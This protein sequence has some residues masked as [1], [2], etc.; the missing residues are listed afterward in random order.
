MS[1]ASVC[2]CAVA[3][4][5]WPAHAFEQKTAVPDTLNA[6][7][8]HQLDSIENVFVVQQCCNGELAACLKKYPTC[9][10][11][12]RLHSF[13]KWLV[14]RKIPSA[15]ITQEA[16]R[17]YESLTSM[18]K[19]VIDTT[20]FPIA[21]DKR[22]PVL[23]IGYV[24]A[25]CPICHFVTHELYDAV[26]VGVLAG[27]AR[28]MIKPLGNG[29]ANRSLVAAGGMGRFWDF[30][31]S[32]AKSKGRVSEGL[33]YAIADSLNMSHAAFK[34]RAN[35]PEADSIVARSTAEAAA[36]GVT[37]TPTYFVDRVRYQSYKDPMW[38]IDAAEYRYEAAKK[39]K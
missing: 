1:M 18:R 19:G 33:I 39:G 4:C 14:A 32:L 5:V 15:T 37:L 13:F 30:F 35:S 27:K 2:A 29:F 17:R 31:I 26:T 23:I 28:L 34:Q 22:A 21:G 8:L 7:Q 12:G 9:T 20:L 36:S 3:L 25:V 10:L 6:E 24:S 38:L 16:G 11:A